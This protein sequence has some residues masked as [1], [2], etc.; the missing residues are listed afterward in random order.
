MN[1]D[2]DFLERMLRDEYVEALDRMRFTDAEKARL[3]ANI[4]AEGRRK[5][6]A[7]LNSEE[8]KRRIAKSCK[9]Q[10]ANSRKGITM[11]ANVRNTF[12]RRPAAA[13]AALAICLVLPIT[14]LAASGVLKGYFL[15]ATDYRGAVVGTS[16]EQ[17][18]DE[19]SMSVT[20]S[21][22]QLTAVATF[23]NPQMAPY[24]EAEKLGIAAYQIV[25]A[26]GKVVKEG[27]TESVDIINGQAAVGIQLD[28]V[29]HG[30]YTLAVTAFVS[31]KK[32]DQPL[33]IA[34]NWECAFTW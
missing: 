16:Y 28:G 21:G 32:A 34:G 18:T 15:D 33:N 19:I 20:V 24:S 26:D 12:F 9:T 3:A 4:E 6:A 10:I 22:D 23:A 7:T 27:S 13:F 11:K 1:T 31:E 2:K 14:A 8:S 25:D 17:A 5:K 30:S 29:D